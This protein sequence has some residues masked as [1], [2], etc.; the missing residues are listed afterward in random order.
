MFAVEHLCQF[1]CGIAWRVAIGYKPTK[2]EKFTSRTCLAAL[3]R[4]WDLVCPTNKHFFIFCRRFHRK[5]HRGNISVVSAADVLK[6]KKAH[7]HSRAFL[8]LV[9]Y[10]SVKTVNGMLPSARL[11]SIFCRRLLCLQSRVRAEQRSNLNA[12]HLAKNICDEFSTAV[13]AVW[14]AIMPTRLPLKIC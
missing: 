4:L 8:L 5:R 9:Y 12:G 2:V 1:A 13:A 3:P 14:L 11:S 6:S 10:F 7:Q